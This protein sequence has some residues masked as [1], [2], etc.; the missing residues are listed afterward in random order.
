MELDIQ[1]L[2]KNA[3]RLLAL[4]PLRIKNLESYHAVVSAADQLCD[5]VGE[6]EEHSLYPLFDY[7]LTI[8]E[9]WE[10]TDFTMQIPDSTPAQIA[11]FLLDQHGQTLDDIENLWVKTELQKILNGLEPIPVAL[12]EKLGKHFCVDPSIFKEKIDVSIENEARI[13]LA[14]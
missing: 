7:I 5:V 4:V 12:A 9:R 6:D 10:K 8:I 11:A 2:H 1:E 3:D 14:A 13:R